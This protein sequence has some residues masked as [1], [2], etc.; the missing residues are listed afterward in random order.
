[1]K[2]DTK[3]LH[4]FKHR[5]FGTGA[6]N[7]PIFQSATFKHPSFGESTGY[8]YSRIQNPTRE[9]AEEIVAN[10]EEG[11]HGFGFSTG[12]AAISAVLSIIPAGSHI[13]ATE[14][15]YGGTIK[16]LNMLDF[17]VSYVDTSNI[18][19]IRNTI[20]SNTKLIFIETPTNPLLKVTD[21]REV[22]SIKE[23]ILLVVDNTL[24]T[25]YFQNPLLLGADIT[26]H[27]GTKYL[28]GHSDVLAG[29]VI[30]NN[31]SL[32]EKIKLVQGTIGATLAPMEAFLVVRGIKTLALRMEKN[33]QNAKDIANFLKN[34]PKVKTV[35]YNG[36]EE[37]EYY[38]I[39]KNQAS[40][41]GAMLSFE[42]YN[43]ETAI[44]LVNNV[45]IITYA[46]SLGCVNTLVTIP[47]ISTHADIPEKERE[48]R[49]I[50]NC[51]V[52]LS[53]GIENSEDLIRDLESSLK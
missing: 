38:E 15:L 1:M 32:G 46:E 29:F 50:T 41:F 21:I 4:G 5:D 31:D 23:D 3:C 48:A 16:L 43:K 14:D 24:L 22:A 9:A 53:V 45:K 35:Y 6:I 8:D 12:M 33:E 25:P 27:S 30:T 40:G 13:I 2:K 11:K 47:S 42:A 44:N 51:L 7:V 37:S 34:H 28:G 18:S 52:R 39:S 20:K 17:E 26:I 49:G 10:L 36:F 19:L